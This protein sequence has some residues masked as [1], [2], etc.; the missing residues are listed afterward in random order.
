MFVDGYR[1][2]VFRLL[3]WQWRNVLLFVGAACAAALAHHF[4][5]SFFPKISPIPV[6][7]MGGAVGIFVSF[8]TNSAYQRW[9]EGRQLWGRL[10]N[11]SRHFATQVLVYLADRPE[12]ARAL[13]RRQIAYAHL[14]R[15]RLR[16]Q[17]ALADVDV[18]SFLSPEERAALHGES[19]Q[20]HV[21]LQIQMDMLFR[22]S[23]EGAFDPVTMRSFDESIRSF[24]DVQGGCE[25][26]KKTPFPRGY[27]FISDRLVLAFGLLL[28]WTLIQD[29]GLWAMPLSILVCFAFALIGEAGRVLEDPFSMFWPALPLSAL[30]RTIEINLRQRLGDKDIPSMPVPDARGV[31]M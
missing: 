20:P 19:S 11:T 30:S 3:A 29:M 14:L 31:L 7:T 18:Q 16:D 23:K 15:C 21:I 5:G 24:L 13:V 25:R 4:A 28:P 27:T 1:G 22:L 17:D 6:A 9:W 8:R 2:S 10:I 26:I 12:L